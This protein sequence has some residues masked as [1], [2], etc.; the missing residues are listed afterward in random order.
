LDADGY[1]A[2]L[3]KITPERYTAKYRGY[4][5]TLSKVLWR[6]DNWVDSEAKHTYSGPPSFVV[7]EQEY[8]WLMDRCDDTGCKRWK[9]LS[10]DDKLAVHRFCNGQDKVREIIDRLGKTR[11]QLQD[12]V[13]RTDSE[14][15][16]VWRSLMDAGWLSWENEPD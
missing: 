5:R 16:E 3:T 9:F 15:R 12:V 2:A 10:A 7:I 4:N 1:D 14:A 11:Q 13:E 8:K 6:L